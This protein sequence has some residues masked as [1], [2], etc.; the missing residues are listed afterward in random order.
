MEIAKRQPTN[1]KMLVIEA[2]YLKYCITSTLKQLSLDCSLKINSRP[3]K[4]IDG[5][6][7]MDESLTTLKDYSANKV[8]HKIKLLNSG[9]FKLSQIQF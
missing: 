3:F 4:E 6:Y 2:I 7:S 8:G 5:S 1:V 9:K